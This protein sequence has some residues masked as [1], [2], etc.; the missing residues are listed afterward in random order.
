M[1]YNEESKK[2]REHLKAFPIRIMERR[3]RRE[4]PFSRIYNN[5]IIVKIL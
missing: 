2:N 3:V 1:F 4:S 5:T